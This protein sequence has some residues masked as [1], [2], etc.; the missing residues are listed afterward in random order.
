[1]LQKVQIKTKTIFKKISYFV[2]NANLTLDFVWIG[3]T[4]LPRKVV[5]GIT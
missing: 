2:N 1:M 5:V 4:S 3:D